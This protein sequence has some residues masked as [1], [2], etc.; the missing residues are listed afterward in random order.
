MIK[1]ARRPAPSQALDAL[2]ISQGY[3]LVDDAWEGYGRRTYV[4]DDDA[5]RGYTASL[6]KVLAASGWG[7]DRSKMREFRHATTGEIIELEPGGQR[8][9]VIFFIISMK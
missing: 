8:R 1:R 5:T 7:R 6:A 2:L 3:K 4:H 9:T